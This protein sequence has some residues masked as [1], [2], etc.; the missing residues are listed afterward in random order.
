MG[1]VTARQRCVDGDPGC[2]FDPTPGSCRFKLWP[3]V[4][5]A[6]AS[7]GCAASTV[8]RLELRKPTDR[9]KPANG[10]LRSALL[11]GLAALPV[12]VGPGET[13]GARIAL[14][15]PVGTRKASIQVRAHRGG[16]T[17][18]GDGLKLLCAAP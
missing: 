9:D 17:P 11:A 13:C 15:V 4:G 14:D 10:P 5:T 8:T 18:D 2:D 16:L 6:N 3:C 1:H 7:A 12:P